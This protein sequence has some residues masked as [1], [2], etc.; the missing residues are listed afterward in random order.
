[1]RTEIPNNQTIEIVMP[2]SKVL[3]DNDYK[4]L[5]NKLLILGTPNHNELVD[6]VPCKVALV[7]YI[8]DDIFRKLLKDNIE[9]NWLNGFNQPYVKVDETT[10]NSKVPA[11]FF[12]E[13]EEQDILL[14][15]YSI[16]YSKTKDN[17]YLVIIG[18]YTNNINRLNYTN[19]S[20]LLTWGK[21][22]G[23]TNYVNMISDPNTV[24]S[25]IVTIIE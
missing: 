20:E 4:E 23:G 12:K 24:V 19:Y 10:L 2:L 25:E 17:K 21:E 11:S 7:N 18:H 13:D 5:V 9:I 3:T 1:M 22:Y 15:D 8:E 14:K 16:G 6:N